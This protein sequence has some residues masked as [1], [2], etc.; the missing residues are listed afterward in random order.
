MASIEQEL[1]FPGKTPQELYKA[2]LEAYP[3]AGFKIWKTRELAYL[4]MANTTNGNVT[5]N[6]NIIARYNAPA[7]LNLSSEELDENALKP[8]AEKIVSEIYAIFET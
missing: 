4:V 7:V 1:H 3:K 5:I 8:H 2:A 6:S